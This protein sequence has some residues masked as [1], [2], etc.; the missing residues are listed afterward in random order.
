MVKKITKSHGLT[1]ILATFLGVNAYAEPYNLTKLKTQIIRYHDSGAYQKD[2]DEVAAQATR[3]LDAQIQIAA[4]TTHPKKLAL[5]LDID[6]TCLSNYPRMRA[7]DFSGSH[8]LIDQAY[9]A[10]NARAIQPMLTLY[11]H[12]LKQGVAVFFVTARDKPFRNATIRNLHHAGYAHWTGL[13]LKAGHQPVAAYKTAARAAIEKRGY[14]IIASIGDQYSDLVGG[15]AQKTFK[16]PNPFYYVPSGNNES[17][18]NRSK[19]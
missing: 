12:A 1:L 10:A 17:L 2:I 7:N 4:H 5:V 13:D 16:L 14:T 8:Q 3:Y 11:Q 15:Y 18:L 9:L 19:S 6:E